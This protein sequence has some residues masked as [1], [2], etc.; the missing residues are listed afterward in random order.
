MSNYTLKNQPI[1][2]LW[3]GWQTD[4][5]TLGK[6]GWSISVEQNQIEATFQLALRHKQLNIH[7]ISDRISFEYEGILRGKPG[8]VINMRLANDFLVNIT[9][10]VG[11]EAFEPIDTIP[12]YISEFKVQR[13]S[14]LNIFQALSKRIEKEVYLK[15]DSM[16]EILNMALAQQD[17]IQTELRQKMISKNY[18]LSSEPVAQL[19][20]IG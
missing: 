3:A 13:M 19:R 8:P 6:F 12:A 16:S 7:G 15:P 10:P 4:T 18:R 1:K 14:D 2:L 5:Y 11:L 20:L 9:N 17:P